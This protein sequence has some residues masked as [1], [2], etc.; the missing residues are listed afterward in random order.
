MTVVKCNGLLKSLDVFTG[1]AGMTHALSHILDPLC[2]CDNAKESQQVLKNLMKKRKIPNRP[3][4]ND[5]I[6]L[7][8]NW[9]RN[10]CS[11]SHIDIII[12]GFP[13]VGFS[14]SGKRKGFEN[15]Q[16]FLFHHILRLIDETSCNL[17]F[18]ENVPYIVHIGM[19]HII[20]ELF[21][22][23]GFELRWCIIPA[24]IV[25]S[26]QSRLRWY[27]L[28]IRK[29]IVYTH[30]LE[31]PK[32]YKSFDWNKTKEP[33][34]LLI[35]KKKENALRLG[36]LGNSVVPDAVRFAFLYLLYNFKIPKTLQNSGIL[37][38]EKTKTLH[39]CEK[40]N[41]LYCLELENIMNMKKKMPSHAKIV[42][43][44]VI[45]SY[46]SPPSYIKNRNIVLDPHLYKSPKNPSSMLTTKQIK[47]PIILKFWATP[48]HGN[49][50]PS[51]FLTMR[52]M[53]DLPTQVRFEKNT[54]ND[55]RNGTLN[56]KFVEYIMGYPSG[57]T[58]NN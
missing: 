36:L 40:S 31:S 17:V 26:P 5:I 23:R 54:Q 35:T 14:L 20:A 45:I 18:L 29:D 27:C 12:G 2:Y 22:K 34:R 53:R 8:K 46:K 48:R 10:N 3:I 43:N 19:K 47:N 55:K 51:N 30:Y 38:F 57:W 52:S 24:S 42:K 25:G 49:I 58:K 9:I 56:P 44:G 50:Y 6:Y 13:C 32:L 39:L 7:N 4:C 37:Q 11:S 1:I 41:V 33:D 21:Y 15:D 28:A 16:S